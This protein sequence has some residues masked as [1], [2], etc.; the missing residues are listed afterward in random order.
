MEYQEKV[1]Q[2]IVRILRDNNSVLIYG[3]LGSGKST[4][5]NASYSKNCSS[6]FAFKDIDKN[7]VDTFPLIVLSKSF[8]DKVNNNKEYIETITELSTKKV[9]MR[10]IFNRFNK[11][12]K[13]FKSLN[14]T[15]NDTEINI[16]IGLEKLIKT[17]HYYI[18]LDNCEYI[19]NA[20]L[21]LIRKLM[22]CGIM[23]EAFKNRLKFIFI[24][25]V[26]NEEI[27]SVLHSMIDNKVNVEI[28]HS[29]YTK[30]I[31]SLKNSKEFPNETIQIIEAVSSK[32]LA[33]TNILLEY[34]ENDNT[35]QNELLKQ[36]VTAERL[37]D[38]FDYVISAHMKNHIQ[39]IN[40]L[41]VASILGLIISSY[42]LAE[43]TDKEMEFIET[44]LTFGEQTGLLQK[45]VQNDSIIS[46]L[47]PIIKDILYKK[48][49]NKS[50]HHQQY[51]NLLKRH[52]PNKHILIAENLY[53][54]HINTQQLQNEFLTQLMILSI[55][56]SL[57]DFNAEEYINKYFDKKTIINF[58]NDYYTAI[59]LY[60]KGNYF[61]SKRLVNNIDK[62]D[63][64][65]DFCKCL[66]DYLK[67]RIIV[68]I[69]NTNA[70][71][72]K[73]KK[74]LQRCIKTFFEHQIYDL[75][76]DSLTVL[77][78]V[79]AYKLSDLQSARQIE[80]EYVKNY[81]IL[82]TNVDTNE[83]SDAYIEFLRR[84]ASLLDAEGAY[85]RMTKLFNRYEIKDFL[86]KY[87]AYCDM[88]GY[89]LYAGEFSSAKEYSKKVENYITL[90]SFYDFPEKYKY[91]NNKVLAKLYYYSVNS[92]EF[93]KAIAYGIKELTKYENLNGVSNVVKMNIACLHILN[94]NFSEAEKRLLEL[95]SLLSVY[96]NALYNTYVPS[97]LAA[98]YLLKKEYTKAADFNLNA[99]ENL[100][101]WDA[102]YK[103]YYTYQNEYMRKL[104][105]DKSDLMPADLFQPDLT[106]QTSAKTYSFVGRGIM[107]SELLF[108]TL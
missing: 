102:N 33:I 107:L 90:N 30:Y 3:Q 57:S 7:S 8:S 20:T 10:L 25:N 72:L 94:H 59:M 12:I 108:Y 18:I 15:F 63:I 67:A 43:L 92:S 51:N 24:E 39:E 58:V 16:I 60:E 55:N 46:F 21:S 49:E 13:M 48:L 79:Y 66:L 82:E 34:F 106:H 56:K 41:K 97:N 32:D 45:N 69:G 2:N 98:L 100:H 38:I 70:D 73:V 35:S 104:I 71:Y 93:K 75:Y 23:S 9:P 29:E 95:N 40:C 78:N 22:S 91:I 31:R 77:L 89:S 52:Y 88:V 64:P 80:D 6:Y 62:I 5:I 61:E 11:S 101:M 44:T 99:K 87:K 27:N 68:V 54:G 84:T 86:P 85:T 105:D 42:D 74:L 65:S 26:V 81:H 76:F 1:Y 47:H 17:G 36:T 19:N 83:L 50:I 103:V 53:K 96:S 14:N 37:A 4:L 28:S